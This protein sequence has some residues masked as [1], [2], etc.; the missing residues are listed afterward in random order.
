MLPIL[1]SSD[2]SD[3][4]R[5]R[6]SFA[7]LNERD[8]ET[9]LRFTDFLV[10]SSEPEYPMGEFPDPEAI[11]R[12]EQESVVKAIKRLAATY[13][14][15]NRDK[16]LHQTSDLMTAHLINGR[17]ATEVIDELQQLFADHYAQLKQEFE[18]NC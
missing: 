5:L 11:V 8:K 17:A 7:K 13:P 16:L 10:A 14:M 18:Q 12:P 6:E 15:I 3:E 2:G 4:K 9:L 1:N